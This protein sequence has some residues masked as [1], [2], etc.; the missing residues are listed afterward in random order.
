MNIV[1]V[2][3]FLI[4]LWIILFPLFEAM[5]GYTLGKGLFNLKVIA[6]NGKRPLFRHLFDFPDFFIFGVIALIMLNRSK[7]PRRIGDFLSGTCVVRDE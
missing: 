2:A 1:V 4:P 6:R 5:F 3:I 7:L